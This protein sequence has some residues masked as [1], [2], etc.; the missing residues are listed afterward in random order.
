MGRFA[1]FSI[2]IGPR[3]DQKLLGRAVQLSCAGNWPQ[4][5]FY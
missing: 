1:H 3:T 4:V 2:K 5:S